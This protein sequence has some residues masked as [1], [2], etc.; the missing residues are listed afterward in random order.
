MRLILAENGGLTTQAATVFFALLVI[1][2]PIVL[3]L[4]RSQTLQN[5]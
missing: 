4:Y 3:W 5:G 1:Q 2:F